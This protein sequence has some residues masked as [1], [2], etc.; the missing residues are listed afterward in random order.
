MI[1]KDLIKKLNAALKR[2]DQRKIARLAGISKPT[3]NRFLNGNADCVSE[4]TADLIIDKVG[5]L[6]KERSK[7]N[8]ANER[9]I[10]KIINQ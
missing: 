8:A 3:V 9:K 7:R 4:E 1:N 10:E 2:G 5:I 6:I